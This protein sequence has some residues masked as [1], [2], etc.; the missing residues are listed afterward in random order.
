[1]ALETHHPI[2]NAF[3]ACRVPEP[4]R[5]RVQAYAE[6]EDLSISQVIRK[7]LKLVLDNQPKREWMAGR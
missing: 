5:A 3:V 1:M 6:A 7:G 4:F 2:A